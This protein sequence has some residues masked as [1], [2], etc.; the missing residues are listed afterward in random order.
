MA[1]LLRTAK[2][3]N[4]WTQAELAAYNITI[5]T[6]TKA[7]FFETNNFPEPTYRSLVLF[8]A[9]TSGGNTTNEDGEEKKARIPNQEAHVI[10]FTYELLGALD[11]DDNEHRR[12][13]S[14]RC[15]LPFL[16]C[17][18][19]ASVRTDVCVLESN[20]SISLLVQEGKG[21]PSTKDPEPQ[22]IAGAIAA[23]A[24]NN[25]KRERNSLTPLDTIMFPGLTMCGTTPVFYKITVTSAL[26]EAV[27]QGTYPNVETRVFRYVPDLPDPNSEG[28]RPLSNRVEILRYLLAFK[29]FMGD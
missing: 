10:H 22:L 6:Q 23:F 28:M 20:R 27:Q 18:E 14:S 16:I 7:Q 1:N 21:L 19:N 29:K 8:M 11:Y 5:V 24:A 12:L 3:G 2:S 25:N 9:D 26:S 13:L 17:G 15:T 4:D